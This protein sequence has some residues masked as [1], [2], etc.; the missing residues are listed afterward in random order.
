LVDGAILACA[1]FAIEG[2]WFH[3]LFPPLVLLGAL[4]LVRG[5]RAEYVTDRGEHAAL[6]AV[7]AAFDVAEPAIMLV[8]LAVIALEALKSAPK[9][10]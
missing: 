10:G 2:T 8:S 5:K 4:H 6:L 1:V 3:R 7:A 9:R